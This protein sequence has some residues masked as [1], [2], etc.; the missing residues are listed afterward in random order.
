L[1]DNFVWTHEGHEFSTEEEK[2]EYTKEYDIPDNEW[3]YTGYID[4]WVFVQP[5]FSNKGAEAY[6][7]SNRHNLNNPR[8][9]VDSAYR[10]DEWQAIREVL[11]DLA[12]ADSEDEEEKE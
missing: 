4:E 7:A 11:T 10:N 8:V 12:G 3:V 9:Y 5:F 6:V 2:D 1:T